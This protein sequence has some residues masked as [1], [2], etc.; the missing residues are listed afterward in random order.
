[1][2]L[3]SLTVF[4]PCLNDGKILPKLLAKVYK[5]LGQVTSNF[6]VLIIDDGST[7]KSREVVQKLQ[8]KY[9]NLKL[10]IHPKNLGYGKTLSTGFKKATKEWVFY[11]DGDGQYDPSDLV[12]LVS[13]LN[14]K[15]DAV[16]GYKLNRSDAFI[17][18]AIGF[19]YNMLL[20]E[21][22]DL[23]IKD[24]DCDF[25]LIKRQFLKNLH[26]KSTSGAICLE[27]VLKLKKRGV[28]FRE[29]GISHY[30][31]LYGQSAFFNP[32]NIVKTFIENI[33]L[34]YLFSF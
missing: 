27:L 10:Y 18:K 6:E 7:D 9:K 12:K 26:F 11:T 19:L 23:P 28:R 13:E 5:T 21:I 4:F 2:K 1:M 25:R 15:T 31:R 17:R 16:N 30:P 22:Y 20:H 3:K 14:N 32:V 24:I 29:I 8:K 33:R 34:L